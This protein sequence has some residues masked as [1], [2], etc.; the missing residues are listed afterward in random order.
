MAHPNLRQYAMKKS[1]RHNFQKAKSA[2][3]VDDTTPRAKPT[4][5]TKVVTRSTTRPKRRPAP[6]L[7]APAVAPLQRRK[8]TA[9]G[10]I[11]TGFAQLGNPAGGASS[12]GYYL[13]RYDNIGDAVSFDG[14][15]H[16]HR[17]LNHNEC[18]AVDKW[19]NR[20]AARIQCGRARSRRAAQEP[21]PM[22]ELCRRLEQERAALAA[23]AGITA[24]ILR[25]DLTARRPILKLVPI[26]PLGLDEWK[27]VLSPAAKPTLTG[28]NSYPFVQLHGADS[29]TLQAE[30]K[31]RSWKIPQK[32]L[33]PNAPFWR[34]EAGAHI[35]PVLNAIRAAFPEHCGGA[36]GQARDAHLLLQTRDGGAT[37]FTFHKDLQHG[38]LDSKFRRSICILLARGEDEVLKIAFF[39]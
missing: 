34:T 24:D 14:A 32:K 5:P 6:K 27:R 26:E 29:S 39:F 28:W 17:T 37:A 35:K 3:T 2:Q 15:H 31:A 20:S 16:F 25:D 1:V 38:E 30:Q 7:A 13:L 19:P 33:V 21:Q 12:K 4:R 18:L 9:T 8:C 22:P 36:Q 10:A 23:E 11:Q